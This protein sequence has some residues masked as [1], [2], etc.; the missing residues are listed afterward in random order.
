LRRFARNREIRGDICNLVSL[1]R[2]RKFQEVS[3]II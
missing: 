3:A 2:C 1:E